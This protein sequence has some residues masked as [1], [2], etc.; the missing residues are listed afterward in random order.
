[1]SKLIIVGAGGVFNTEDAWEK[2]RKGASL[3]QLVTGMIFEGPQLI[4]EIN[5]GLSKKLK[6][7]GFTLLN[8]VPKRDADNKWICFVHPKDANGVL[9]ELCQEINS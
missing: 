3:I 9:V 5:L 1:M 7:E 6:A 8:E 4:G 2:I